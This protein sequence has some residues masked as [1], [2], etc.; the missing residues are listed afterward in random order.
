MRPT[1]KITHVAF[2]VMILTIGTL[3]VNSEPG[4]LFASID[5]APDIDGAPGNGVGFIYKYAPNGVLSTVSYG[6]SHPRGLAFDSAGNLFV[7]TNL[8]DDTTWCHP[9]ILK[10]MPGG[11]PNSFAT[12]P[13]SFFAQGVAIDCSDNLF[14]MAIGWS[15]NV[16]IILKLT[17]RGGEDR[18]GLFRV[19]VSAWPLTTRAIFSQ[20]TRRIKLSISSPRLA[21]GAYSLVQKLSPVPKVVLSDWLLISSGIF[22]YLPWYSLATMIEFLNLLRAVLSAPLPRVSLVRA[23]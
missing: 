13:D 2:Q 17:P 19:T 1:A 9:K 21:H 3:T 4:D 16:S 12:I 11:A 8:C 6:L 22:S 5:G 18:L 20:R 7:A 15:D 10:I 14:V 23:A